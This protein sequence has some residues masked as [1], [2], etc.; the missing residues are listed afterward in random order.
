M[1]NAAYYLVFF[2]FFVV[3]ILPAVVVKSCS[4][5]LPERTGEPE[6]VDKPGGLMVS[7]YVTSKNSIE[8]IPLEEYVKGVVAAEM[9]AGFKMEALKAQ[10]VAARTYAYKRMRSAGGTGCSLHPEA[11]VCDDPTHCQAWITRGEMLKKWGIFAFYHYYSKISQA[12]KSTAGMVILYQGKPIDPLFHSTSGGKTEN[13]EDVWGNFIP[14]LRS[15]TSPGEETS[16]RFVAVKQ[17]PVNEVVSKLRQKWPDI[18][19]DPRNPERQWKVVERSEGGRIKKIQIGNRV[20]NGTEI[21]ELFQLNSTNFRW[22]RVGD[23]IKFTT[24]GYGH[25]V[26]MSQYGANAMAERGANY[27]DILKHYYTGVEVKKIEGL[28]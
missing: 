21:R 22:E 18:V 25:G 1:R 12:V 7:L 20:V 26:G 17:V 24:V 4:D 5:L 9:P 10:A 8:K 14:Y 11:D 3:I 23:N 19:L 2:I 27:V 16:P 15:V 6:K 13:S 28:K